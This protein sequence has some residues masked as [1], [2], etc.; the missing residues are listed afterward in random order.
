[1][2]VDFNFCV[3]LV[4]VTSQVDAYFP[5][6]PFKDKIATMFRKGQIPT[7][8]NPERIAR[9]DSGFVHMVSQPKS[10]I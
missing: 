2:M 6:S 9:P 8:D 7:K 1:M 10:R 5:R 3:F 4:F